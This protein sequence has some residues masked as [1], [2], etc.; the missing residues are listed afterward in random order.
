MA[1]TPTPTEAMRERALRVAGTYVAPPADSHQL[2]YHILIILGEQDAASR[3]EAADALEAAEREKMNAAI[4]AKQN[5]E[6]LI[7]QVDAARAR[8]A[9]LREALDDIRADLQ[10]YGGQDNPDEI[11]RNRAE[12]LYAKVSA[13][14]AKTEE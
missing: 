1:D 12:S 14:L 13:A 5:E 11:A 6:N 9:A 3:H 8:E 2:F 10:E 7:E 4:L